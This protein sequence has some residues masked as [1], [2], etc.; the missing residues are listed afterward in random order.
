MD[1]V[2]EDG[3]VGHI[4][5]DGTIHIYNMITSEPTIANDC[6]EY[7]KYKYS[8]KQINNWPADPAGRKYETTVT[9]AVY[10]GEHNYASTVTWSDDY[11]AA[12]V[13]QDCQ[14]DGCLGK[15]DEAGNE[16]RQTK[17]AEI[18][19]TKNP[20]TVRSGYNTDNIY[21][22]TR[23][24]ASVSGTAVGT[25]DVF[26]LSDSA[27]SRF[28]HSN[29]FNPEQPLKDQITLQRRNSTN[30]YS[31]NQWT[32][33]S[34]EDD[35]YNAEVKAPVAG[36]LVVGYNVITLT[37]NRDAKI[38][39]T[40]GNGYGARNYDFDVIG[41][42]DIVVNVNRKGTLA[43]NKVYFDDKEVTGTTFPYTYDAESHFL[44]V[45]PK[46]GFG[47]VAEDA[48]VKYAIVDP[49]D[50]P[51]STKV[52]ADEYE[53]WLEGLD[54]GDEVEFKDA[55]EWAVFVEISQDRY[56]TF[57]G[58]LAQNVKIVPKAITLYV[59]PIV[60]TEGVEPE[61][62]FRAVDSDKKAV[63][64]D[65]DELV[66]TSKGGKA[67]TELT[68]SEDPYEIT[69]T[70]ENYAV[71]EGEYGKLV[72]LAKD[73]SDAKEQAEKAEKAAQDALTKAATVTD[74]N[75]YPADSVA[76]VKKAADALKKAETVA[77]KIQLTDALNTA[78]AD[79]EAAKKVVDTAKASA[80]KITEAN[81]YTAASVAA[82]AEAVKTNDAAKINE[83]V[84]AAKK[85]AASQ[86]SITSKW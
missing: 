55:G 82:V 46:Y 47:D 34:N 3:E 12:T 54:Y 10:T 57:R 35:L 26:D 63:D 37:A 85:K 41:T 76:A 24:T 25:K 56:D 31:Q 29:T 50:I 62:S 73:G 81:G 22:I 86:I 1:P 59:D 21:G 78:L 33:P 58:K 70:S 18:S 48:T 74:A 83:A 84:A 75:G 53:E 60:M 5:E 71:T 38:R 19:K 32:T 80:A 79:A 27:T 64:V 6:S 14:R 61:I 9:S 68:P 66:I 2:D 23:L 44:T 36:E 39:V 16:P 52:T 43:V 42:R 17:D 13:F 51:D 11:N 49:E 15:T 20:I 40:V 69:V 72:V 8:V 28:N 30:Q 67:L 4:D 65:R 45:E 7:N 77:E